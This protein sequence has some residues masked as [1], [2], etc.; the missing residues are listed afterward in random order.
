MHFP[1]ITLMSLIVR[2]LQCK[3]K[4]R[5]VFQ[6]FERKKADIV[7][8][9]ECHCISAY[10]K[11]WGQEWNGSSYFSHGSTNS[12]GCM[13]LF[14][15]NLDFSVEDYKVD[16]NGRFIIL[17][18]VIDDK[19]VSLLNVYFP[20]TE[21]EQLQFMKELQSKILSMEIENTCNIIFGGDINIVRNKHLDKKGG[22]ST[23]KEKALTMLNSFI[24]GLDISDSWRIK[25]S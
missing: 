25:N 8:L 17:K 22:L 6:Y 13:V 21:K 9:Q 18:S 16:D 4:R 5:S 19:P 15:S 24:Y 11:T 3:K 2:G 23:I 7:F 12:R 10:E 1:K 20:N 14:K